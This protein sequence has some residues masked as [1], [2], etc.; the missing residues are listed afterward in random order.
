MSHVQEK[1]RRRPSQGAEA[2]T[3]KPAIRNGYRAPRFTDTYNQL[4]G[5]IVA[6][7]E[8]HWSVERGE[9]RSSMLSD[10]TELQ[11]GLDDAMG[12]D[13]TRKRR[14]RAL[15]PRAWSVI[16]NELASRLDAIEAVLNAADPDVNEDAFF[17]IGQEGRRLS[18]D[19]GETATT[20]ANLER[21]A[22]VSRLTE[23]SR[24]LD[25]MVYH[26]DLVR[27]LACKSRGRVVGGFTMRR[28][29]RRLRK[30][31][32]RAADLIDRHQSETLLASPTESSTTSN[33]F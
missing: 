18:G 31:H 25:Q 12:L 32:R 16:G 24:S 10:I 33:R 28:V 29:V 13:R 8:R 30:L 14:I 9:H 21:Q 19:W 27:W 26:L 1:P 2:I 11:V 7:L 3:P 20:Q 15:V 4:G 5:D 22:L 23:A 17:W 6:R